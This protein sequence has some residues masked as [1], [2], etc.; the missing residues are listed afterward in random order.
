MEA[1]AIPDPSSP[2]PSSPELSTAGLDLHRL[3]IRDP[4]A[5]LLLRVAGDSMLGAGIRHGDLLVVERLSGAAERCVA[6][7][8][9]VA[10]IDDGFMLKRL[11]WRQSRW[12]LEAAHPAHAPIDL[13]ER[14][15]R[16]AEVR[17]WGVAR[18][19]IRRLPPE[20]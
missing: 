18:Q 15:A 7:A 10:R 5:S 8:I 11:A 6:G 14:A 16:G 1:A 3:L 4:D 19:V 17:L 13:A 12:W 2:D 9:V 20:P